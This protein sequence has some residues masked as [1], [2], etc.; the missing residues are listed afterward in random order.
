MRILVLTDGIT[1]FVT[2]GMQKHSANL[3]KYLI[4]GGHEITLVHCVTG[5]DK[6]PTQDEIWDS[7][8]LSG[9]ELLTTKG[10][11][12]PSLGSMPGH[13]L[14]ESYA[15]SAKIYKDYSSQ[16]N[17]FDFIYAKGFCA[18]SFIEK[19]KKGQKMP[20]IGV[21]FHGY[22]MFQR[23]NGFSQKV[24]AWL[25]RGAVKWNNRNADYVFSYGA[26]ITEIIQSIGVS[27]NAIIEIPSGI[28]NS[29]L[30]KSNTQR[31]G[32]FRF[33]FIGRYELRKGIED[34]NKVISSLPISENVVFDFIGEIPISKR[35]KRA[36]ITYHGILKEAVLIKAIMD[37]S[38]VL[39]VPS[40]SEGMPNV[41]LEGMSRG[42]AVIATNVG[43]V[44]AL[45]NN[46]NGYLIEALS[47]DQ[48]RSAIQKAVDNG[49][50][51]AFEK[52][53]KALQMLNDNFKW[54]KIAEETEKQLAVRLGV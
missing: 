36:D 35:I 38:D 50:K 24:Q 2:G 28:D 47:E 48:L 37:Q 54:D 34:L 13:Y 53:S 10:Y 30:V 46:E 14:K 25:L 45:V 32:A 20:P 4:L 27:N 17:D 22:E 12:F 18:W 21:K 51:D 8:E 5:K 3:V 33:L 7:L 16:V 43:A 9:N 42:L 44:R 41:I 1:P 26:G 49:R 11:R 19:K 39:I 31:E 6:I 15:Y 52:G 29:W 23:L 40:H